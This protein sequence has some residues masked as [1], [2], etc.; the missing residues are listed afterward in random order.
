MTYFRTHGD[1]DEN[2]VVKK[3]QMSPTTSDRRTGRTY[4]TSRRSAATME[5]V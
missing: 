3:M 2:A 4:G 1:V 5:A